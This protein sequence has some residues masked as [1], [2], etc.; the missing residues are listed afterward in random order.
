MSLDMVNFPCSAELVINV[1]RSH[2][3]S[4]GKGPQYNNTLLSVSC[5]LRM[6]AREV[7]TCQQ[8]QDGYSAG[9]KNPNLVR[10]DVL[11]LI[12]IGFK[13]LLGALLAIMSCLPLSKTGSLNLLW[14]S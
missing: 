4:P 14:F 11:C 8:I 12:L 5:Q 7:I 6:L 10:E 3:T 1:V 2:T 9:G 13:I